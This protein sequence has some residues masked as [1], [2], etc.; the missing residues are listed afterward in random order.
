MDKVIRDKISKALKGKM[1]KFIPDN[2]GIK[3]TQ[4][5]KDKIRNTLKRLYAE[6]KLLPPKPPREC[7][8]RGSKHQWW[9]GGVSSINELMRKSPEYKLWR[10]AVFA[11]DNYTCIW[12][13]RKDKTIK[14]DHI[15]PFA[16]YPELRFAI[17]NG[18]T[19]CDK[20]HRT[21][22]TYGKNRGNE[23]ESDIT[24]ITELIGELR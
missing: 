16:F 1:P 12:C 21:T 2:K 4:A 10:K 13:G 14:A 23:V 18:R 6:G 17:D 3:R 15:K 8:C 9:K 7:M 5:N 20:C 22:E 11:R 24:L 19:L